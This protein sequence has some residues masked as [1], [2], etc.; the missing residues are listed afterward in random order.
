M[1]A[2]PLTEAEARPLLQRLAR[3]PHLAIAV[4]GGPDSVALMHL[5]ALWSAARGGSP[6][7]SVLTVDHGLRP[8]SRE[9]ALMVASM[10]AGLGLVHAI[11]AWEEVGRG[12]RGLQERAR[13]ARYS[14][15]ADY[16][17]AHD[18]PAIVT[19]HH[20]DDQAETFLMR[21]KRG[22]GL[23]GLAAIPEDGQWAGIA[24]LRPLLDVP[25]ARLAATLTEAGIAFVAD[26]SNA[27]R[28]FERARMRASSEALAE[29]GLTPEAL[30]LSAR[31]LRRAREALDHAAQEFLDRHSETSEAGYSL[32]D[33]HALASTPQEIALR[34]LSRIISAVGGAEGPVRLAKLEAL[35]GALL[36]N[37]GTA[38]TLGGCRLEPV[39]ERLGIFREIRRKGLPVLSLQPGQTKLWDNRFK[40]E[41]GRDEPSPVTVRALGD[42]GFK[43]LRERSPLAASLPRLAGRALP[44]CWRGDALL[45]IPMLSVAPPNERMP[46]D[47]H[48][49]FV[50]RQALG[51]RNAASP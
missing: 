29:L 38:H 39:A 45:G 8:E 26:A 6:A 34:A 32:I 40:I 20:L 10:A 51:A 36:E 18:I 35:L 3:Y 2:L 44:S 17:H 1:S 5:A 13:A 22:S 11:L 14:L 7:L 24:I 27:D 4:S 46:V 30:A 21:L 47:C 48:A 41:L 37:S 28:R 19:A 25:K 49:L 50:S 43:D 23:D 42:L 9:E 12:S 31:R 33:R 15:M 16:C